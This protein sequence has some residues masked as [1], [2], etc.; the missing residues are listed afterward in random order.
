M[1]TK[2]FY[3]E[4]SIGKWHI[5][6]LDQHFTQHY[7]NVTALLLRQSAL[8]GII[9]VH[10]VNLAFSKFCESEKGELNIECLWQAWVKITR[11][12][13]PRVLLDTVHWRGPTQSG[14]GWE[15]R[16]RF[17][18]RRLSGRAELQGAVRVGVVGCTRPRGEAASLK[19]ADSTLASCSL[20][21]DWVDTRGGRG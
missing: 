18:V 1:M 8:S 17:A 13:S 12:V 5:F 4:P 11:V 20:Q 3:S 15:C 14:L 7:I 2:Q 21:R 16:P 10:M 6:Q 9:S 19:G